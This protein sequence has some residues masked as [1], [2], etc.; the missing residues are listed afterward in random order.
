MS[1]LWLSRPWATLASAETEQIKRPR[2]EGLTG[3]RLRDR[4]I[5]RRTGRATLWLG[6]PTSSGVRKP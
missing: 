4:Q 3:K 6:Q 5:G 1:S 2:R